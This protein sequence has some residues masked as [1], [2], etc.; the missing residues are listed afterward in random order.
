MRRALDAEQRAFVDS[1][2]ID[3][4]TILGRLN[5]D[6][7]TRSYICCPA[8][9]AL[10]PKPYPQVCT[11]KDAEKSKPCGARMWRK[12][13]IRGRE[14][15][16]PLRVYLY[17]DIKEW[18][19]RLLSCP[20]MEKI[21]DEMLERAQGAAREVMSDLWDAPVFRELR[22]PDGSRFV[23][24][25]PNEGRYIFG[26]AIDGFNPYQN[27]EAKQDV[28]V[29]AIYMY[30]LSLPPHL[31]Y[32]PENMCLVGVIPG[33]NKPHLTQ[34][35]HFLQILV[36]DLMTFYTTGVFYSRTA[37]YSHGRLVRCA[38]VPLVCDLPAARQTAGF[39]GYRAKYFC[40][41]CKLP[42]VD[43]NNLDTKSWEPRECEDHKVD[44]R[45]WRNLPS[46]QARQKAFEENSI[47]WSPLVEL[48]YW[49][50]IRYTVIDS[51]H[52]HYLG[53][54]KTH[55][56]RIWGMDAKAQDAD[57]S[58]P[59]G[60]LPQED[61]TLALEL[62]YTGT[63]EE[64][65]TCTRNVLKYLCELLGVHRKKKTKSHMVDGLIAWVSPHRVYRRMRSCRP[66]F[67]F[68]R[69]AAAGHGAERVKLPV[70][71][72]TS[73]VERAPSA[74]TISQSTQ[75]LKVAVQQRDD[76]DAAEKALLA[77]NSASTLSSKF[78][79][80]VFVTLCNKYK[81]AVTGTKNVMIKELIAWVG[82]PY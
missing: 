72:S 50:P 44:A 46:V 29:T 19:A 51:M 42:H 47:R 18:L 49:D 70:S 14:M 33:P 41:M 3:I 63:A 78:N 76:V 20:G 40:S 52:N 59:S 39:G 75:K 65:S 56:R 74:Q 79:L 12:R 16:F 57:D 82:V 9:F 64:L 54:L 1:L 55:C 10:Y 34:L 22:M 32:R 43:I 37:E 62:V 77:G 58:F 4:R 15:S 11:H 67:A 60:M 38:L 28:S 2:P 61:I 66:H 24:A 7:V 25:P 13:T 48:P 31:R 5:L 17:Q 6:P 21:M 69:D 73:R 68:Q 81:I 23:D 8:C 30:C 45:A 26:L 80:H 27:K 35:N 71:A 53:L 36:D